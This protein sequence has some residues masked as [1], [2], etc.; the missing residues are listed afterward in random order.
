MKLKDG[1]NL[2]NNMV[3]H[4]ICSGTFS[5]AGPLGA[6]L[7]AAWTLFEDLSQGGDSWALNHFPGP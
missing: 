5:K 2:E 3:R 6:L 4:L 7:M 1:E